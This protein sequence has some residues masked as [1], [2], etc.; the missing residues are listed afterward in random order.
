MFHLS[1][2]IFES[3]PEAPI[4]YLTKIQ[5]V[6]R[7]NGQEGH[8]KVLKQFRAQYLKKKTL[9]TEVSSFEFVSVE[10]ESEKLN[11]KSDKIRAIQYF[12]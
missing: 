10:K 12:S 11:Q 9:S 1:K 5:N 3:K 2:V 7:N 4:S 8:R 6:Y